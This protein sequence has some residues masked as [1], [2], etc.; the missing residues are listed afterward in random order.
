MSSLLRTGCPLRIRSVTTHV[1]QLSATSTTAVHVSQMVAYERCSVALLTA[2]A[3]GYHSR[4]AYLSHNGANVATWIY[5]RK[6]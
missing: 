6:C 2:P 4:S 3:F 1:Y 5:A